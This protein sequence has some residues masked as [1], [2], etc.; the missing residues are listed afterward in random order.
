M[1]IPKPFAHAGFLSYLETLD[2]TAA[3]RPADAALSPLL[4]RLLWPGDGAARSGEVVGDLI[5]LLQARRTMLQ[6]AFETEQVADELRR[7][8]KFARPGQPSPHIVQLRRQQATT[9]LACSQ[10][11][12]AFVQACAAFVR[13]AGI[14]VPPR[15]ALEVFVGRWIEINLPGDVAPADGLA[16]RVDPQ[17]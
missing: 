5:R 4:A 2:D 15:V 1:A 9:R 14:E 17:A 7:Y 10:S 8:Q 11:R 6:V 16:G 3:P 12:Q 13:D